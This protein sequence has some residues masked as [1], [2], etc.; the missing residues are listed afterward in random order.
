MARKHWTFPRE[1]KYMS[2][3]V[4][5]FGPGEADDHWVIEVTK[6]PQ[7]ASVLPTIG[8]ARLRLL[9]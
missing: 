5:A 4:V 8:G 7:G 3:L 9:D 1:A 6:A 2:V